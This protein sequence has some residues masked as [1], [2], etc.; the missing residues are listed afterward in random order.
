MFIQIFIAVWRV[1][2]VFYF[3]NNNRTCFSSISFD[4][5]IF[6]YRIQ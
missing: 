3:E 1:G 5:D 4:Y 6:H 2:D